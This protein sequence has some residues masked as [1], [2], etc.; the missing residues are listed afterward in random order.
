MLPHINLY[1][2]EHWYPRAEVQVVRQDMWEQNKLVAQL[3]KL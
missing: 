1:L 2:F 3:E